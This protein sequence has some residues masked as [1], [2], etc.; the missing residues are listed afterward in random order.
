MANKKYEET[1]VQAIAVAIREKTGSENT[2]NVSE[3]ASGVNEVYDKGSVDGWGEFQN[4]LTNNGTRET[5]YRAFWGSDFT[6]TTFNPIIYPKGIGNMF[7]GYIGKELPKGIDCSRGGYEE[8]V[9]QSQTAP[10][11]FAAYSP[12][13]E[14]VPDFGIKA[15]SDY[16]S[17][18]RDCPKLKRIEMFRVKENSTFSLTFYSCKA[19]EHIRFE[20][21]FGQNISFSHSPLDLDSLKDII[22]H[23]KN[24][25]GTESEYAYTLTLKAS[26]V[27][28]LETAEITDEDKNLLEEKGIVVSDDTTWVTVIDNLKWNLVTA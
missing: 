14:Y 1:D 12:N 13:L 23:L 10:H 11:L 22:M 20:G 19:L 18:F 27:T 4:A 15:C 28:E 7:Y 6:G 21:V 16:S 5:Y 2:Y 17:S 9:G 3:M 26:C 8:S 25:A 24:Y